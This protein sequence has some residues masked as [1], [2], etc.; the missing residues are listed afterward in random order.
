M[1]DAI[2]ATNLEKTFGGTVRALEL[3]PDGG[4]LAAGARAC[5][6]CARTFFLPTAGRS[7]DDERLQLQPI[8]LLRE[9][10]RVKVALTL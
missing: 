9:Q 4:V 7:M 6:R 2:E 1:S 8:P 10:G 5:P 3:S